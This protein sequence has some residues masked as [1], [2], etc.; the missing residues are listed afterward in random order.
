MQA[1][2]VKYGTNIMEIYTATL[3]IQKH[4]NWQ[5]DK[6][7]MPKVNEKKLKEATNLLTELVKKL[8]TPVVFVVEETDNSLG[9]KGRGLQE[10]KMW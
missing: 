8:T 5:K 2:K 6:R 10:K 3:I 1:H 4:L 9:N 7:N